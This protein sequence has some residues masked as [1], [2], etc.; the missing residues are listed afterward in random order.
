MDT[1]LLLYR[2]PEVSLV[3]ARVARAANSSEAAGVCVCVC[4]C[5]VVCVCVWGTFVVLGDDPF[6]QLETI[7][8]FWTKGSRREIHVPI[9]PVL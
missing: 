3:P 5:G 8:L 4:V 7:A 2:D 1:K 9:M 6:C